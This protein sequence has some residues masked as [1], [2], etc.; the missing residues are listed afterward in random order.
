MGT[1]TR[2]V[3]AASAMTF[4]ALGVSAC[5]GSDS[6]PTDL[7]IPFEGTWGNEGEGQPRLVIADD[8][9]L[10]GT[11]G[12]NTINGSWTAEGDTMIIGPMASTRMFCEGVDE[13]LLDAA[14]GTIVDADGI[15]LVLVDDD[16]NEIGSLVQQ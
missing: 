4:L 14:N 3:L 7:G 12:C 2:S 10:T 13:W 9:T 6:S 1:H 16:G 15:A 8:G 11:T 5:T